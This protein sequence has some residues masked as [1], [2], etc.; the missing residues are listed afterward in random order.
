MN[1][2]SCYAADNQLKNGICQY[3]QMDRVLIGAI[4]AII[5]PI[6]IGFGI[7]MLKTYGN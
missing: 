6:I 2:R 5:T 1:C 7:M 4:M 3:C